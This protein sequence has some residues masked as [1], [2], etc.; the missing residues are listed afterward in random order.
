MKILHTSDLHIKEYE[1]ARWKTLVK[2]LEI[3]T[4]E[5]IDILVICGD[6]FDRDF[7][8]EELR[9]KLRSTFSEN[10][11]KIILLPGNHDIESYEPGFYF[12]S[13]TVILNDFEKPFEYENLRIWGI[14]FEFIGEDIV[15]E[16]LH[17]IKNKLTTDKTNILLYHGELLD[18]FFSRN[19]FGDEGE[20]R[21]MPVKLSYF[22]DLNID[23]VLAG[24]FHTKFEIW[25]IDDDR[26]FV[27]P[28]SPISITK[29]EIGQRKVNL[30]EVGKP[31]EEFPLDTPHFE[32]IIL[33]LDP[34]QKSNPIELVKRRFEKIHSNAKI[35][36]R[37]RGYIN[38]EYIGL[39]E[40][41]LVKQI[42]EIVDKKCI[43]QTYEFKDIRTI[44]E[45][46]LFKKFLEKLESTN[47]NE[48]AKKEMS[49]LAIKAM[50]GIKS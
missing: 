26:Y 44:L 30:F 5:K 50:T 29:R 33:E 23:Y 41:D 3:G 24:H 34:F 32:E 15:L 28:S 11:F 13:N 2:L 27:Y 8:A 25:Q 36:L 42:K 22:K 7:N 46:D 6:L 20:G 49:E 12:G 43:D 47:F 40:E 38:S 48:E 19:E 35:I 39:N 10:D 16:K 37:V 21:Y 1:D 31:P 18:A 4:Q 14:P 17:A 9:P 45:D